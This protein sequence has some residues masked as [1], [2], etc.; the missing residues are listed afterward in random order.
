MELVY[1]WHSTEHDDLVM[2]GEAQ[3]AT[4]DSPTAVL[5]E[6]REGGRRSNI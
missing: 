5:V 1:F 2:A 4:V 6:G 3:M